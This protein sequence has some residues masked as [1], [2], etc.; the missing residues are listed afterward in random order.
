MSE[1]NLPVGFKAEINKIEKYVL[2][3]AVC[4]VSTKNLGIWKN[5]LLLM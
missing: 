5:V 1:Q 3:H 2:R 4:K